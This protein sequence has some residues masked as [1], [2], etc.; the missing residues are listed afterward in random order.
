MLAERIEIPAETASRHPGVSACGMQKL[1]EHFRSRK[2][3][4]EELPPS[5]PESDDAWQRLIMIFHRINR[6]MYPAFWPTMRVPIHALVTLEWMRG[7]SLPSI[8]QKRVQ[9][10]YDKGRPVRLPA[11]IR[12]TMQH[13]EETARFAAPKFLSCYLDIAR[14]YMKE[15]G[16]SDLYPH[17]LEFDIYLEFGV[18]TKTLISLLGLGLSRTSAVALYEYMARDDLDADECRAWAREYGLAGL[19]LPPAIL[20]EAQRR[21]LSS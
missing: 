10:Q 6:T 17:H 13:V 2:G 12:E 7:H 3:R 21:L 15:I 19:D 1:L 9:Y 8:I 4:P 20:R 14:I 18:S 11:L 16:R 5:A